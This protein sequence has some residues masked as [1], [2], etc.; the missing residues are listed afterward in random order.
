LKNRIKE[1]RILHVDLPLKKKF[2]HAITSRSLSNSIFLKLTLE[3]GTMGYGESLPR[4]YV[5]GET[6]ESVENTLKNIAGEKIL[7]FAP[8]NYRGVHSLVEGLNIDGAAGC[9][10]ELALLNTFGKF[11]KKRI[12][13][14]IGEGESKFVYSGVIQAGSVP[15]V[16]K[17]GILFR[18]YGLRYIKVKVGMDDDMARLRA[19]RRVVGKDA[20][21]RVDANCAWSADEAIA[22]IERMRECNISAVEQPVRADDYKGLKKVTCAVKEAIIADESLCTLID[23]EMLA[24]EKAC[25]IFNIRISKCGGIFESLKIA[26]IARLN[27]IGIQLGCQVGESGLLSAAGWHFARLIP[28]ISFCEGA[29]GKFLLKEDVAKEDMTIRRGGTIKPVEGFGLGVNISEKILKRY[30][31]KEEVIS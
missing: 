21:I 30:T 14:L 3:D 18:L 16:M 17:S 27:K 2:K 28:N 20:D 13:A 11:F 9:A 5:T 23:A 1:A 22:N 31:V 15:N 6:L 4:K 24:R 10:L 7:G 29:Y 19:V 26:K 8:D 25:N 12:S